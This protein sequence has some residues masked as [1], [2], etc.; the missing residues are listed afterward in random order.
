MALLSYELT[1]GSLLSERERTATR[2]TY[3]DA[4]VVQAGLASDRSDVVEVLRSLDTGALRRPVLHRD[5]QWYARG[6]DSGVTAAIPVS[7]QELVAQGH[8]GVQ[9][10]RTESG[11]ALVFGVPLSASTAFYEVHSLQELEN[12]LRVLGLILALVAGGTTI[13]GAGFGWYVTRRVLRPLASV[14]NAAQGIA[15]GDLDARLDPAVE[16]ELER[17]TSSFNH[18]VNQ[19]ARRIERD[20]RFAADVSHEL[21]SPLQT[22]AAAAGVLTARSAHLDPRSATAASLVAEEVNRFQALVTDLLELARGDQPLEPTA[23]DVAGLARRVCQARGI[24]ADIVNIE[25]DTD[26]VWHVDR[27]RFEQVL[28]NLV[29]NAIHHGGGA[30]AI[31]VGHQGGVR[32]VEVDDEGP[33]VV[34]EDRGTIFDPFVRG[35]TANARG[36]SNGTGLGLALVAQHVKAHGGQ[37]RMSDR[38]GGGARF[39][40]E[41]AGTP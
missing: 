23:V 34:P 31:S 3:F 39:R 9:R 40:I 14:A 6:A 32:F 16:P 24:S 17:L 27:R 29:E 41:L 7:L 20:R 30:V 26:T 21:R 13:A 35:R 11:A 4:T 36:D 15:A 10:V 8:P 12:T 37:I 28:A 2:T 1:R 18:M 25:P 5:G 38:P 19:L 22:L 33:G